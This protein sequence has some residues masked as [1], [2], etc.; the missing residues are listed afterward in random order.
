MWD[1]AYTGQTEEVWNFTVWVN[2]TDTVDCVIFRFQYGSS[3]EW[4]N[5]TTTLISGNST[6]GLYAYNLTCSVGW[7]EEMQY[8]SLAYSAFSFKVFANDSLGNWAETTTISY[9][10]GYIVIFPPSTTTVTD[11]PTG[12]LFGWSIFVAIGAALVA[13]VAIATLRWK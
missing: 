3:P 10:G 7:N 11:G 2:D 1:G 13:I 9:T 4:D 12:D 6:I 5:K 8:P